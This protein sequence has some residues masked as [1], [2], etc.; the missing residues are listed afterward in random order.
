MSAVF[1]RGIRVGR[2]GQAAHDLISSGWWY[3]AFAQAPHRVLDLLLTP[4]ENLQADWRRPRSRE[5]RIGIP[6]RSRCGIVRLRKVP[7]L[8]G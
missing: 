3:T 7:R 6:G 5:A 1:G 2:G 4:L 8:L